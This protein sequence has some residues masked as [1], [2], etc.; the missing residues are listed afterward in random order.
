M[1]EKKVIRGKKLSLRFNVDEARR[2]KKVFD[3]LIEILE[4]DLQSSI[5]SSRKVDNYD[6]PAWSEFQA[7]QLGS[8]RTLQSVID[9]ITVRIESKK[10]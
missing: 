8:Q 7:D 9:L 3:K 6:K 2:A 5:R 1:Q 4:M 10:P